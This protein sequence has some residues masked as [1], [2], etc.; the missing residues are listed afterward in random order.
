MR[1]ADNIRKLFEKLHTP[2]SAGL[3]EKIYAEISRASVGTQENKPAC[4]VL[5]RI[6]MKSNITKFAAAAVI[7]IGVLLVVNH[8][9]GTIDG[10]T[11]AFARIAENMKKM[12]WM[13]GVIEGAG[14]KLEGWFSFE[15]KVVISKRAHGDIEYHDGL[16]QTIQIYNPDTNTISISHNTSDALSGVGSSVLDFPQY[17]LKFF[18]EAGNK[19]IKETGKYRGKESKIYKM[20]GFFGGMDMRVEMIVDMDKDILLF[21]NQKAFDQA[22][23]LKMEANGYFDYPENGP[24]SIYEVGVPFSAKIVSS[25]EEKSEDEKAFEKAITIIN[26]RENWPEPRDLVVTYWKDRNAKNYDEMSI[27]WPGSEIW[28]HQ[29]IDKE[30]VVEY[31]FGNVQAG[32]TEGYIIIPYAAKNYYEQHGT[33]NLKML[34]KNSKSSKG[35]YYIVSGN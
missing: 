27:F 13:H 33:Y 2:T 3:D 19:V 17:I 29:V 26:A 25:E 34:L 1:H 11:V 32:E 28:N 4:P 22:G 10:T 12:P 30:K 15:R 8:F 23:T 18:D 5:W 7:I 35:R 16:K 14:E 6:I 31:I 20:S 24:N 21:L 9:G